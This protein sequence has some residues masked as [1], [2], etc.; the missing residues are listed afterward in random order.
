[1]GKIRYTV[2]YRG[3][4][5]KCIGSRKKSCI[6]RDIYIGSMKK[7]NPRQ[8]QLFFM[9]SKY[10]HITSMKKVVS[11]SASPR[12]IQPFFHG[13]N[14]FSYP[15][16]KHCITYNITCNLSRAE[17]MYNISL[18]EMRIWS[19]LL[20]KSDF[21]WCI[22]LNYLKVSVYISPR[23]VIFWVFFFV[24]EV[25]GICVIVNFSAHKQIPYILVLTE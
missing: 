24:L 1:M 4:V 6:G 22:H 13:P 3:G 14:I 15:P 25:H 18:P 12:P 16:V 19:I 11:S 17:I 20:I 9:D 8:I 10:F 21:K 2:F 7:E 23:L 5:R